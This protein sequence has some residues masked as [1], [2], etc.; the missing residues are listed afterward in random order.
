MDFDWVRSLS[1]AKQ[2]WLWLS[3]LLS[4][5]LLLLLWLLLLLLLLLLWWWWWWLFLFFF[6]F[7]LRCIADALCFYMYN[8]VQ[9]NWFSDVTGSDNLKFIDVR[10]QNSLQQAEFLS[11]ETVLAELFESCAWNLSKCLSVVVLGMIICVAWIRGCSLIA[12]HLPSRSQLSFSAKRFAS[13]R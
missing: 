2:L 13:R 4:V 11:Q 5:L 10:E 3:M 1:E 8:L 6:L 7:D 9:W 12:K